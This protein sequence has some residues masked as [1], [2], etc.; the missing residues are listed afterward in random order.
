MKRCTK[1]GETKGVDG[2]YRNRSKRDGLSTHCKE[3]DR[4][5]SSAYKEAHWEERCAKQRA[6]YEDHREELRAYNRDRRALFGEPTTERWR[7]ITAKH[8]TRRGRWSE[9]ED[10]HLAASTDR[11]GDDA[12]ALS[13]TYA[14]VERRIARLRR[15]CVALARD[16]HR[17]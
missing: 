15:S 1:C 9:A 13:R 5:F 8:A 14:S 4:A 3:C 2:F 10:A 7:E 6:Y 17:R 11:V 12:L 16:A